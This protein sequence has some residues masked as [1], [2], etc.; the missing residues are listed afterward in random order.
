MESWHWK[1]QKIP[2]LNLET[3]KLGFRISK[4][5]LTFEKRSATQNYAKEIFRI[6]K[7]IQAVPNYYFIQSL[8]GE[9]V[10]GKL[11]F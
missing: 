9:R 2:S 3:W 10:D 5:K 4:A 1:S 8:A 7:V 11:Y 6:S